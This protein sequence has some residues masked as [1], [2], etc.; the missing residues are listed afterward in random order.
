MSYIPVTTTCSDATSIRPRTQDDRR[1]PHDVGVS[2]VRDVGV[3]VDWRVLVAPR[4]ALWSPPA[5]HHGRPRSPPGL[6]T[7]RSKVSASGI[8]PVGIALGGPSLNG[9]SEASPGVVLPSFGS[10]HRWRPG[11]LECSEVGNDEVGKAVRRTSAA[12]LAVPLAA[13]MLLTGCG[14]DTRPDASRSSTA[15]SLPTTTAA[16]TTSAPTTSTTSPTTDPN[17]PAAARAHTAAGAEAFAKYFFAQL[18]RSWSTADPSLLPPLSEP[19]CKTCGAFTSSAASFRSKTQHYKGEVFSV[20]SI[21]ALGKGLRGEEV[22]VVGEQK[23][24]AIVDQAGTVIT[25]SV[26]QKGKF[27]V[28][29]VWTGRGWKAVELQVQK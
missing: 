17:I 12:L 19:G 10:Q 11:K 7:M 15:S 14:G 9:S 5:W 1:V 29:L 18:N 27:I 20:T 23:P 3:S 4:V 24:G 13:S 26:R 25:A 21:G 2:V 8:L 22:L 6:W 16:P 28:S